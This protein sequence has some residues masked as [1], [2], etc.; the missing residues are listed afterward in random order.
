MRRDAVTELGQAINAVTVDAS[1]TVTVAD[2]PSWPEQHFLDL[3]QLHNKNVTAT[4]HPASKQAAWTFL[5]SAT[6]AQ[7]TAAAQQAVNTV[8]Q[9]GYDGLQLDWEGL[10]PQV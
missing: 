9:A 1:G 2:K 6:P 7:I 4:C 3:G 10:K 8:V 5:S